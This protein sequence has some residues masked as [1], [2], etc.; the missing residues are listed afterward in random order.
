MRPFFNR[1]SLWVYP[2]YAGAGGS[3]GWWMMGVEERQNSIL[4]K[5]KESLLEK[6]RRRAERETQGDEKVQE[7]GILASTS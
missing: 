1:Q 2:L 3:F 4:N 6:R 7:A 5:R